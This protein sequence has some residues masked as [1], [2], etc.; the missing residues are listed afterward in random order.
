MEHVPITIRLNKYEHFPQLRSLHEHI[1]Q[2]DVVLYLYSFYVHVMERKLS[3]SGEFRQLMKKRELFVHHKAKI[4]LHSFMTWE[5][6]W[7][8]VVVLF[9]SV[10]RNCHFFMSSSFVYIYYNV[11]QALKAV[12]HTERNA[13]EHYI[14]PA[15]EWQSFFLLYS[16]GYL[17]FLMF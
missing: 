9:F 5:M 4:V 11:L 10:P 13:I 15:T 7:L 6:V 14:L 3:P 17:E 8:D 1:G 2:W 16:N 12:I